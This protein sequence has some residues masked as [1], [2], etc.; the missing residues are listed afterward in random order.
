VT[1][2]CTINGLFFVKAV[3]EIARIIM[4]SPYFKPGDKHAVNFVKYIATREGVEK[5]DDSWKWKPTTYNQKT[6]VRQILRDFPDSADMFE[7]EDYA[8]SATRGNAS[9]FIT[10]ALE[11]NA[12]QITGRQTYVNY[13]ATR[14][15]VE[16][17]GTHGLFTDSDI[18]VEL[19]K[20]TAE[21]GRHEGNICS[22]WRVFRSIPKKAKAEGSAYCPTL[23]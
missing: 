18:P 14:P 17:L 5:T 10:R 7:C 19:A 3:M 22:V 11:E 23:C 8:K 4:K 15:R 1:L 6:L 13:I 9:E 16:K 12:D 20:V 2:D 21:I